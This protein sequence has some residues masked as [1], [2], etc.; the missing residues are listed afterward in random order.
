MRTF[1]VQEF[2]VASDTPAGQRAVKT[3]RLQAWSQI[4]A[5]LQTLDWLPESFFGHWYVY[6]HHDMTV[7]AKSYAEAKQAELY[8]HAWVVWQDTPHP[9]PKPVSFT[10]APR[11]PN[12]PEHED[13][14]LVT[15]KPVTVNN[16]PIDRDILIAC[17]LCDRTPAG[18]T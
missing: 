12:T 1:L 3:S 17:P 15:P 10:I 13:T 4:D 16:I 8:A 2:K 11:Y 5:V 14:I 7:V 6:G 18:T 9:L